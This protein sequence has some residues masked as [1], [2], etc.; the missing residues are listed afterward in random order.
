MKLILSSLFSYRWGQFL[1]YVTG[2]LWKGGSGVHSVPSRQPLPLYAE[3]TIREMLTYW[4]ICSPK[5]ATRP[6]SMERQREL[7][8]AE[9]R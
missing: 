5:P 9:Q 7:R 4:S 1:L 8:R 3:A 2:D 6:C